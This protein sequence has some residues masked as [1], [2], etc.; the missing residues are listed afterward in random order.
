MY[1]IKNYSITRQCVGG[2]VNLCLVDILGY[3]QTMQNNYDRLFNILGTVVGT[4][5]VTDSDSSD[6]FVFAFISKYVNGL[7]PC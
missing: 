2:M 1:F 5:T 6:T 4:V 7:S 3:H